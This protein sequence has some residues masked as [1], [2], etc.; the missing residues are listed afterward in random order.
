M[1]LQRLISGAAP[2]GL[3]SVQQ[4]ANAPYTFALLAP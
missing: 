4:T 3:R 2:E 1:A